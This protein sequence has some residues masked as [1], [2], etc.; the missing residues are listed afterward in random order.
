M[1]G[2]DPAAMLSWARPFTL[3]LMAARLRSNTAIMWGYRFIPW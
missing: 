2:S 1:S 3:P